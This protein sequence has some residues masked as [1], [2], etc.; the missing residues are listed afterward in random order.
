MMNKFLSTALFLSVGIGLGVAGA[1]YVPKT[2]NHSSNAHKPY[3][4]QEQN[5]ISTL[6][7]TDM[8][9]LIAGAGWGL[10]KP[11]EFN[12][13]PGPAH[14]LELAEKLDLNDSQKAE[15]QKSF[16]S[17]KAKAKELGPVLIEAE[18]QLDSIFKNGV[19]DTVSLREGISKA[20]AARAALRKV[21]LA[22][23]LEVTPLLSQ[24]QRD[25]YAILR[26]YGDGNSSHTG[27]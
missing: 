17:M 18:A 25:K 22:A 12:G 9:Q 27:H 23:H 13:Y 14:V 1:V 3:A 8:K 4:G 16:N 5:T 20:E 21:H 24:E 2:I 15:V 6:S 11:A 10:A 7:E 19:A 26:G